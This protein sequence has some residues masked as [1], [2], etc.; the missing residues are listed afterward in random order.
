MKKLTWYHELGFFNNPLSIK[1]AAFDNDLKGYDKIIKEI[2]KQIA[3]LNNVFIYGK[4]GSG[5]TT[6]LKGIINE[7]KGR[8]QVIY[9]NCNQ[10]EKSIN[11]DKLLINAGSFLRRL[12][13]IRKKNMIILLD[14]A[15]DMNKKDIQNVIKYYGEG[16]FKSVVFVS[17]K[18]DVEVMK[19]M[20]QFIGKNRFMVGNI[21]KQEAVEL[22]RKRIG[23][24]KLISDDDIIKIF[25]KNRNP[26]T[27]LRNCENVM[28][29]AFEDSKKKVTE[30]Y[31]KKI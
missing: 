1:P 29:A 26:R 22:I 21:N 28:R 27:F 20:E 24:L 11:F 13:R 16:F 14:E 7:F 12:F 19:E 18:D 31:I 4:Y 15:Q 30:K 8:K 3:C 6:L 2:N 25:N 23:N 10:S 9:Y 5:K 17:T